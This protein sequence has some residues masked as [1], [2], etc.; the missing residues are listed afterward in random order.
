MAA[1]PSQP[2]DMTFSCQQKRDSCHSYDSVTKVEF[3]PIDSSDKIREQM[4]PLI[5]EFEQV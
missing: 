1:P 5:I 3:Y 4:F 2:H